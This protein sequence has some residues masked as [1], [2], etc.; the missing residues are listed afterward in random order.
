MFIANTRII[1]TAVELLG[2]VVL[3]TSRTTSS[4]TVSE[5]PTVSGRPSPSPTLSAQPSLSMQPSLLPTLS[6]S[7][8]E[9]PS[10]F[11]TPECYD[12]TTILA[13]VVT[14]A[15][16]FDKDYVMCPNTV[17]D[18]GTIARDG[19]EGGDSPIIF[20]TGMRILCGDDGN[21]ANNCI[22]RG[23]S[24]QVEFAPG[25]NDRF[26]VFRAVLKGFI[27]EGAINHNVVLGHRGDLTLEDCIIQ[28][29]NAGAPIFSLYGG[30][31]AIDPVPP[32]DEVV[33]LTFRRTLFRNNVMGA[34]T[35]GVLNEA[36][37]ITSP[38]RNTVFVFEDCVFKQNRYTGIDG[39]TNQGWV[40]KTPGPRVTII[41]TCF[42]DNEFSGFGLIQ[43]NAGTTYSEASNY[44]FNNGNDL[45]CPFMATST[46][47]APDSVS[48]FVCVAA[49]ATTC[50]AP[51]LDGT[52]NI[53]GA[54]GTPSSSPSSS[55]ATSSAKTAFSSSQRWVFSCVLM[56]ILPLAFVL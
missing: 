3:A 16:T 1:L 21:V 45:T 40:L 34:V 35:A 43:A 23:G 50:Q 29:N 10:A 32:E 19:L 7:P 13:E 28:N 26:V 8:S 6:L 41:R 49:T 22:F 56:A 30:F 55:P 37:I 48:D 52:G 47:S 31:G 33:V 44:V 4:P 51:D 17:Y 11:P 18:I 12:N 36:G 54:A 38:I 14:R 42:Y 25:L 27:L 46:E 20:H 39:V 24:Q 9:T 5:S 15:G 53:P 2:L